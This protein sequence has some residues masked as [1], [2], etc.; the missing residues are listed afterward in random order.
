MFRQNINSC[1][2]HPPAHILSERDYQL[3][4]KPQFEIEANVSDCSSFL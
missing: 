2:P 4:N 1:P 3:Y